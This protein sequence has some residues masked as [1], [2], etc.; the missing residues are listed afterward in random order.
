MESKM[1]VTEDISGRIIITKKVQPWE[2]GGFR[3]AP[4]Q[5]IYLIAWPFLL[6]FG[7]KKIIFDKS[8][9]MVTK[10]K[11]RIYFTDIQSVEAS[12]RSK[13]IAS[14]MKTSEGYYGMY[15]LCDLNLVLSDGKKFHIGTGWWTD[16]EIRPLGNRL[17]EIVQKPFI[18]PEEEQD[19]SN[20][21]LYGSRSNN[22]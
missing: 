22:S 16:P 11:Q 2:W 15:Y 21:P 13:S 3:L 20:V 18:C 9:E 1:I 17:A 10:G 7:R 12:K 8:L 6:L 4:E 14:D 5:I 19:D